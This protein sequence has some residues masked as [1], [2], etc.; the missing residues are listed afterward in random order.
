VALRRTVAVQVLTIV[1]AVLISAPNFIDRLIRPL[2]CP[3][4]SW[5]L[6][7]R[8][9]DFALWVV[10]AIP[11]ALM[12]ALAA[13]QLQPRPRLG[14]TLVLIVDL[15]ILGLSAYGALQSARYHGVD[16]DA[17]PFPWDIAQNVLIL[18]PA[19]ASLA[20]VAAVLVQRRHNARL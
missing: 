6:D 2:T 13:W 3:A 20:L 9:T 10:F 1:A 12:L 15:A 5:C 16:P 19:L 4:T 8:G 7:F 17:P 14:I 11:T 18:V